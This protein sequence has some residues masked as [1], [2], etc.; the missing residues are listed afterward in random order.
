MAA[1]RLRF[2]LLTFIFFTVRFS[3]GAAEFEGIPLPENARI[4][5]AAEGEGVQIYES[6][7]DPAGGYKWMLKAPEAELR[8]LAGEVL[9]KHFGGPAWSLQDG[10]ELVGSLPPLKA[11]SAPNQQDIPWLLVAAKSRNGV[12]ILS[13]VEYVLRIATVGGIPPHE[14]PKSATDIV[15][16]QYRAIYLFLRKL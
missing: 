6:K 12:G 8:G 4:V 3:A 2:S 14:P 7:A 11:V 10:S 1:N 9:G 13:P 16:V 5:L 15:R